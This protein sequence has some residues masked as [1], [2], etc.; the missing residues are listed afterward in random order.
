[1]KSANSVT[2]LAIK[3]HAPKYNFLWRILKFKK[4]GFVKWSV[5]REFLE[6]LLSIIS[7]VMKLFALLIVYKTQDM[8]CPN[9]YRM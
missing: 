5:Q 1:M 6:R 4:R 8:H 3:K 7:A 9:Q 2:D